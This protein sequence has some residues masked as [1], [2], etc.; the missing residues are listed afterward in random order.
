[1]RNAPA[2]RKVLKKAAA[3][4]E[5]ESALVRA[6]RAQGRVSRVEL[7]RTLALVPSTAGIYVDRLVSEG[8]LREKPSPARGLGRPP[9]LIELNPR[10][11]RFVG[12]DFD[13]REM[14]AIDCDFAQRRQGET[15]RAIPPRSRVGEVLEQLEHVVR[16]LLAA[17]PGELLGIGVGVPGVVDPVRGTVT[18]YDYLPGWHDVSVGPW[19]AERFGVPVAVENNIRSM[20][21]GELWSGSGQ[22]TRHLVC[23]GV[24]SGIGSGIVVDGQLVRGAQNLAGEIGDWI[25]PGA[26]GPA[27]RDGRG[28]AATGASIEQLASLT[29]LLDAAKLSTAAELLAALERGQRRATTL[30]LEAARVHG[31]VVHQLIALLDPERVV[32][33]GPLVEHE[34]YLEALRAAARAWG[35]ARAAERLATS[36]LGPYAGAM[37][38]AALAFQHWKPSR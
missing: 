1:M 14:H 31:W 7:A 18:R 20:V 36:T 3:V 32:V 17:R 5:Q 11:G 13:A 21:L 33:A 19:L 34:P 10:A 38:A 2:T 25:Y 15:R 35:G 28:G 22:G 37:G 8:F 29:A 9:V 24:R 30:V 26:A 6:V 23:L 16:E 12:L 27:R 4:A